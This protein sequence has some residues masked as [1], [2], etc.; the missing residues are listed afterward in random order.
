MKEE[1]KKNTRA[2]VEWM[3]I[4][5]ERQRITGRVS[6]H[7]DCSQGGIRDAGTD[8]QHVGMFKRVVDSEK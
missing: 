1:L 2:L 3:M 8:F 7:L 6:L 5:I 4:E